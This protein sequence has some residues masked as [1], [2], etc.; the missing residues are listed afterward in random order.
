MRI[1]G[2]AHWQRTRRQGTRIGNF[3]LRSTGTSPARPCARLSRICLVRRGWRRSGPPTAWYLRGCGDWCA[4][5]AHIANGADSTR[6]PLLPA[7]TGIFRYVV[8]EGRGLLYVAPIGARPTRAS[9]RGRGPQQ[10]RVTSCVTD[11]PARCGSRTRA[12]TRSPER[13]GRSGDGGER[14]DREFRERVDKRLWYGRS[15]TLSKVRRGILALPECF[16]SPARR[17]RARSL[18]LTV[19]RVQPMGWRALSWKQVCSQKEHRHCH[20]CPVVRRPVRRDVGRRA[21]VAQRSVRST[22]E[23]EPR[24]RV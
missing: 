1:R 22:H 21:F 8:A 19:I 23:T 2:V 14:T 3:S 12:G 10:A 11:R 24:R 7:T 17:N 15:G 9:R 20:H 6:R 4:T 13:E 5:R 18:Y 16:R